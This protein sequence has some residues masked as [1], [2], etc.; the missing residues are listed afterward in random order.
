MNDYFK[1][2]G[3]SENASDK[4]IKA[5]Y[6]KAAMKYHPDH[7]GDEEKFKQLNEA[8]EALKDSRRRE[9]YKQQRYAQSS[10]RSSN[11]PFSSNP[12]TDFEDIFTF[13]SRDVNDILYEFMRRRQQRPV[14]NKDVNINY[15][16]TL[17]EAYTGKRSELV[18]TLK[19]G[20]QRKID[21]TIPAGIH[22]GTKI[23]YSGLGMH[24][25]KELPPGD[26]YVTINVKEHRRF[27][28]YNSDLQS[29][30]EVSAFDVITG[31]HVLFDHI[32]GSKIK[33]KIPEGTQPGQVLRVPGKGMPRW[34]SDLDGYGDLYLQVKVKVP[35]ISEVNE[36]MVDSIER[37]RKI[38]S[39]AE[40]L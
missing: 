3:V 24:A 7:G 2:L 34:K 32:D 29:S 4:E 28:R 21:L 9:E 37:L 40:K 33:V 19:N 30:I 27:T 26:L 14:R 39:D 20:E 22:D 6:R 11:G 16:I 36:N 25:H 23:R 1:I 12:F 18:T 10:S 13:R 31:K 15:T 5:A 17:E 35:K 38:V 8:Y